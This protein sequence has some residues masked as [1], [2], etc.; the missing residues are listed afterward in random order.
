MDADANSAKPNQQ[1]RASSGIIRRM[2]MPPPDQRKACAFRVTDRASP[3]PGAPAEARGTRK[4]PFLDGGRE[5]NQCLAEVQVELGPVDV[6][7]GPV[8][9]E[10]K[11]HQVVRVAGG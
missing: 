1:A 7:D 10:V 5:A 4:Q 6:V 9:V 11:G 2:I 8:A 3:F